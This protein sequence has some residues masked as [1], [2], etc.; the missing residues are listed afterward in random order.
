MTYD[1][2]KHVGEEFNFAVASSES[3]LSSLIENILMFILYITVPGRVKKQRATWSL[4]R[5]RAVSFRVSLRLLQINL[6]YKH[7]D[8]DGENAHLNVSQ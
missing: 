3:L 6:I 4:D 2:S 5:E 1:L 8:G 7:K